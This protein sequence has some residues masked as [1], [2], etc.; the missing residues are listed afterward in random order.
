[1]KRSLSAWI[2]SAACSVAA[3]DPR[4]SLPP[5]ATTLDLSSAEGI[6]VLSGG[7]IKPLRVA[8]TEGVQEIRGR[9]GFT[10]EL[11]P[12]ASWFAVSFLPETLSVQPVVWFPEKDLRSIAGLDPSGQFASFKELASNRAFL[13]VLSKAN[14]KSS[15]SEKLT[16]VEA[17]AREAG[18]RLEKFAEA[19]AGAGWRILPGPKGREGAWRLPQEA[20][21][22]DLASD[23]VL[24]T[25]LEAFGR[26]AQAYR[27]GDQSGF[28]RAARDLVSQDILV[29]SLS[30][31]GDG[32]TLRARAS[33]VSAELALSRWHPFRFAWILLL[34]AF[35]AAW[36]AQVA[37]AGPAAR[38]LAA[39]AWAAAFAG[40][41][42]MAVGFA[43]RIYVS[44]RAPV[45]DMYETTLWV[46]FGSLAIGLGVARLY[47]STT[48]LSVA[49]AAGCVVLVL[50]DNLPTV[51][52]PAIRPLV[53]VLRSN[54]WLTLHVLTVTL[55]Y[56]AFLLSTG[57]GNLGLAQEFRT[58]S[59][60]F[61]RTLAR[62]TH[63]SMQLG[64][65]LL[66]AGI[67][68]GGVWAD[69]SWGR[70]WGWDPKETW[71]LIA[72]LGYLV[73]LHGR[74]S[75][76]IRVFGTLMGAVLAYFGVVMAWYGVNFVLASGLH[77]YGFSSGGA[78]GMAVFAV[79]QGTF[80]CAAW[81]RHRRNLSC[82]A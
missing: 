55:S 59:D 67:L 51:L 64:V 77:S 54:Y 49:A 24:S 4:I 3:S 36:T 11:G 7:R 5:F 69:Y 46:G 21:L 70:F 14:D 61:R 15:R 50:A 81:I 60:E 8:A 82:A 30:A 26:L 28:N 33:H 13:A 44:G 32:T 10:R 1:M 48:I 42:S 27:A 20:K 62:W 76:W 47:R 66:T 80:A 37:T 23:R 56:A 38:R 52:D 43:L 34:A 16:A 25:R 31:L 68:L 65:L 71:S 17:A 2:L 29:D 41:A 6:P 72:D 35:L 40:L 39:G 75:G 18:R 73:V 58:G 22:A 12:M 78:A 57:L 63:R 9:S 19:A 79:L 53:P 74:F 45:T